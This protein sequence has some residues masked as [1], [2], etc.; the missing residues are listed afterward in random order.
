MRAGNGEAHKAKVPAVQS[1]E[2]RVQSLDW[3]NGGGG[4]GDRCHCVAHEVGVPETQSPKSVVLR[5]SP[6]SESESLT[7]GRHSSSAMVATMR[8]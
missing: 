5:L 6:E 1:P 4:H 8:V 7:G 3:G 2:S